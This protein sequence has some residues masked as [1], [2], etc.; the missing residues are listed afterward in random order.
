M[1][2]RITLGKQTYGFRF[3]GRKAVE[4]DRE[5]DRSPVVQ[6]GSKTYQGLGEILEAC[7]LSGAYFKDL[8]VGYFLTLLCTAGT[9]ISSFRASNGSFT[10]KKAK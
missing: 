4:F 6:V 2:F 10:M 1:I 9:V 3:S 8:A 5:R 7:E